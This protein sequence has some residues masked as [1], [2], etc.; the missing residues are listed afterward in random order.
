MAVLHELVGLATGRMLRHS[1]QEE[2][3]VQQQTVMAGERETTF[4]VLDALIPMLMETQ[5]QP[6]T[7]TQDLHQ[8]LAALVMASGE[9]AS[10][11]RDQQ[12][13]VSSVS[14]SEFRMILQSNRLVSTFPTTMTFPSKPPDTMSLSLLHS[15]P[16]HP[17]T[18][19]CCQTS[20]SPV[21]QHPRQF[22]SI[23]F[24]SSWG[25]VI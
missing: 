21:T 5:V 13:L 7:G 17:W 3:M 9:M 8:S 23:L 19:T 6:R 20:S 14:F 12:T 22:R 4:Q 25:V 10:I 16:T 15:L 11:F 18:T 2:I 24:L 1:P